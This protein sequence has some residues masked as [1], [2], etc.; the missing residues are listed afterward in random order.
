MTGVGI[1]SFSIGRMK[2]EI[3]YVIS[4]AYVGIKNLQ[5]LSGGVSY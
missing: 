2:L 3:N 4:L 5:Q 1:F